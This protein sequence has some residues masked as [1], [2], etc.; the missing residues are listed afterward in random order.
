MAPVPENQWPLARPQTAP[1]TRR[2]H[3]LQ[4]TMTAEDKA[5]ARRAVEM[6]RQSVAN[7]SRASSDLPE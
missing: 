4:T 1:A 2:D 6:A 3:D 5:E 7:A